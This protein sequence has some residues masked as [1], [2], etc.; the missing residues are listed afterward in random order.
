MANHLADGLEAH[1]PRFQVE[2]EHLVSIQVLCVLQHIVYELAHAHEAD[3]PPAIPHKSGLRVVH[4][5][6]DDA[7]V[8]QLTDVEVVADARAQ[9]GNKGLDFLVAEG[10][11]QA[12]LLH[13][14]DLPPQ[15]Q[16]GLKTPVAPLLGG[17]A[18]AVP[19]D[20]EQFGLLRIPFG[21]V[22]QFAGQGHGFQGALADDQVPGLARGQSGPV[23]GLAL[24]DDLFGLPGVGFQPLAERLTHH[25]LHD[26]AHLRVEELHLGL[27]FELG[28]GEF[29]ADDGREPFTRVLTGEVGFIV[30]EQAVFARVIVEG[31][32]DRG[33][34]SRQVGAAVGGVDGVG[35]RVHRFH[36]LR[37]V[38]D[39]RL[40][41]DVVDLFLHVDRIVEGLAGL[42]QVA[43]EGGDA[44]LEV[45]VDLLGGRRA[46]VHEFDVQ[47]PGEEGDFPEALG[48]DVEAVL[49]HLEDFRVPQESHARAR[50]LPLLHLA[51]DFHIGDR[52]TLLVPLPP[53][54]AVPFDHHL[55]PFGER[56]DRGD[57][58]TVEPSRYLIAPT[59]ELAPRVEAGHHHFQRGALHL[60][61]D[62]HGDTAAVILNRHT[63]IRVD[64]DLDA[65]T[66]PG[67]SLVHRVVHH[68]VHH[69]MERAAVRAADVHAR[70]SA[71]RFQSLENLNILC[72]VG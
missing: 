59:A 57:A 22:G 66:E 2:A 37:G 40:H 1:V 26:V 41:Q 34:Q 60:R 28:V 17:T 43:D 10:L 21:A 44:P 7:V 5:H 42:V 64:G 51:D 8:A 3:V 31:A 67:Q 6:D 62:V 69:V 36:V 39:G 56:V 25:R 54:L 20:D 33:T 4:A 27:G 46:F 16:D 14:E 63:V 70:P 53:D 9:R 68:L 47:P 15:G 55:Q 61:V 48:Q 11:V 50:A 45:E 52:P 30:L 38:L 35:E 24:L 71:D 49:Q 29:D 58:H 19:L 23:G 72:C 18:C 65:V 12:G 32:G 13:V